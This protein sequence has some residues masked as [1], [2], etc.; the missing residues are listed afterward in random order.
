[1]EFYLLA[2]QLRRQKEADTSLLSAISSRLAVI[3][4]S[5]VPGATRH[6]G[7][8]ASSTLRQRPFIDHL[9]NVIGY[10]IVEMLS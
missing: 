10:C 3:G 7:Q 4:F 2:S 9:I 1:M 6:L 8:R 5:L